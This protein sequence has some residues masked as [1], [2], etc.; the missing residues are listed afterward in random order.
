MELYHGLYLR[1]FNAVTDALA[2]LEQQNVGRAREIL[3]A[4][5]QQAEERIMEG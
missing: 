3:I 2:E 5:Q 1:L 4:A